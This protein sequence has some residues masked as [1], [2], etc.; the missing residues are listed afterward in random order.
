MPKY[1]LI[2][3]LPLG[4]MAQ[5]QHNNWYFGAYLGM[6]FNG[7]DMSI[8]PP[9][10]SAMYT[11]YASSSY[12]DP[13]TGNLL[14]YTS[15]SNVYN[16]FHQQMPN[17]FNIN[18]DNYATH[19][20]ALPVP[21]STRF[22]YIFSSGTAGGR[23]YYSIVDMQADNGRGDVTESRKLIG[24]IYDL[25]FTVVKQLYDNGYW[26][27]T[28][29]EG[30]DLFYAYRVDGKG[31]NLNPVISKA[32]RTSYANTSF[33]RGKM[34]SS[35]DGEKLIF[36]AG[37]TIETA[38]FAQMFYFDK[39]CGTVTA[40]VEFPPIIIQAVD[41]MAFPA[42]SPNDNVVY[43]SWWY[44]SGQNFLVQYDLTD[45]TPFPIIISGSQNETGDLQLAPDGK[46]Y[47]ASTVQGAVT[48]QIS[49]ISNPDQVGT[50]C[51]FK[52][53]N[54]D[55]SMG[56]TES[57][58]TEHFPSF[59]MDIADQKPG[60]EKPGMRI[61]N[62]CLGNQ[63][64]FELQNSFYADS[65]KW[66]LGDGTVSYDGST[67]HVFAAEGE[68]TITLNWY[69]C[70]AT[71]AIDTI[72][73][74]RPKPVI[75]LGKDSTLCAGS[76][77]TLTG[78]AGSDEYKWSTGDS[79]VTIMV[80][81]PGIYRLWMRNGG[82][83]NEDEI[84]IGYYPSLWTALGDEYFICDDEKEL[85]KLDAGEGFV[86]YKWTPTG[87]STQWIEVAELGDYF[88]VV[89]DFRGCN[90]NDGTKVKRRCPVTVFF[91][92]VFTPND[93]GVNDEYVPAGRDITAFEMT[94]YNGWGQAVFQ[95]NSIEKKWDGTFNG[96]ASPV[97]VYIYKAHYEGYRNKK[98][99]DFDTTGNITLIR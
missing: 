1:I 18:D 42:F 75:D 45:P 92:N 70:G 62:L 19:A 27:I 25:Q 24:N 77:L 21:G 17:G 90:G 5:N 23:I 83:S 94:I 80:K 35:S 84:S 97:G 28:H 82:C 40:G 69:I 86:S 95:T 56:S 65:I 41:I 31:V 54:I 47:M 52:L 43:I 81:E 46:I 88:V 26:L 85:T 37:T 66:N 9:K 4:L 99:T 51:N 60:Y 2:L 33:L 22:Y 96:K 93:D 6:R 8:V 74:I 15:G 48:A 3:L 39:R 67:N 71:Y 11:P 50:S 10:T 73:K 38:C 68:Y 89:K 53:K 58:F 7:G 30:T 34:I 36:T 78:P 55:L 49:E 16:R 13:V 76:V 79:G 29:G 32:G 57:V 87:D 91:P 63:S 20:I 12:S 64:V 59:M 98:I 44:N 61:R 72:I 14:F